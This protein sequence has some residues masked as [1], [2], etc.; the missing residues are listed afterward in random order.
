MRETSLE[1]VLQAQSLLVTHHLASI[2]FNVLGMLEALNTRSLQM[3][4]WV[5][6][7]ESHRKDLWSDLRSCF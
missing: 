2:G 6:E 4:Q 7:D 1:E 3:L 5:S